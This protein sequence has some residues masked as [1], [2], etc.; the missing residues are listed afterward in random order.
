MRVIEDDECKRGTTSMKLP[1]GP[2]EP[3]EIMKYE[4]KNKAIRMKGN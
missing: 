2:L 4:N 1:I 3:F